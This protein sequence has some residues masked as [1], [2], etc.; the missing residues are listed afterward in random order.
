MLFTHLDMPKLPS[1]QQ[2]T[3]E[4]GSRKYVTPEGISLPSVTT[5]LSKADP[6][7][8][9]T[10]NK[11]RQNIGYAK[12]KAITANSAK[13]GTSLHKM[14][15]EYLDN[16]VVP[17]DNEEADKFFEDLLP[18]LNLINNIRYQETR[19]YSIKLGMAGTVD[20]IAEYN[21]IGSVI[22]FKNARKPRTENMIFTYFLQETSYGLMY[23]EFLGSNYVKQIVT[24]MA[25]EGNEPQV[26][27]KPMG[28]YVRPLLE[29]IR[30]YKSI[31]RG[32]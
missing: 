25:V 32:S 4:N 14:I 1:L 26:F 29:A 20:T 31:S 7:K 21:G 16:K 10:L 17:H 9:Y 18:Y 27:I 19:L 11:W 24:L 15:E 22:D 23:N 6:N 3:D 2:I 30:N 13:R 12:A 5:V 8:Q 28:P